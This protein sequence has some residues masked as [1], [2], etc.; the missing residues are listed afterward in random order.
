[1]L[2]ICLAGAAGYILAGAI[3][4]PGQHRRAT[5]LKAVGGRALAIELGVVVML[6]LAGAIEGFVSPSSISFEARLAFLGGSLTLWAAYFLLIG[7]RDEN[8][9]IQPGHAAS[10]AFQEAPLRRL[11]GA[12]QRRE[13]MKQ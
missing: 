12:P 2:A 10:T 13:T 9:Q 1:M 11:A 8:V 5:A 6:V 4:A 7:R 3:I